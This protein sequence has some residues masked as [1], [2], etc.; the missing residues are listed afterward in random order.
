MVFI[1]FAVA[2]VGLYALCLRLDID[3][4]SGLRVLHQ[5]V[6]DC[7]GLQDMKLMLASVMSANMMMGYECQPG[8]IAGRRGMTMLAALV[9]AMLGCGV[10]IAADR[11]DSCDIEVLRVNRQRSFASAVPPGNYSGIAWLGGSRYAV[12]SDK[13]ATDGFFVFDIE[14]DSVSGKIRSVRNE[15]F[16]SSGGPNRDQEGVAYVPQGGRLYVSGE[17]DGRVLEY[18]I[19]GRHTGRQLA[20]PE[21]F[22]TAGRNYGI[23]ALTYSPATRRFWLTTESTLPAD[24]PQAA[25]GN[26][27]CNRLRLQCFG[28]SLQPGPFYYYETD[29]P[30]VR[31]RPAAYAMGV[32]GLCALDDGRLVVMEREFYVSRRK[33]GSWVKVKLYAVRPGGSQS[34]A[35]LPKTK[36]LELKTRLS[37]FSYRLANYE[38]ICLGPRLAGG[39][40]VLLMVSD[41]QDRY[42][43]VLKDYF[44]TVVVRCD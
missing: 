18:T 32:S 10:V 27:T 9:A 37:L 31:R 4:Q 42:G 33:L 39:G 40:R 20:L 26:A 1:I 34:G 8:K 29:L 17:G 5:A 43:G 36:V 30:E 3:S 28:D 2:D 23:E 41:S 19:D 21:V 44:K 25:Y 7:Y 38:G 35:L 12:V 11:P 15:G 14:L 16:F 22:A 24:G 13:S 6:S